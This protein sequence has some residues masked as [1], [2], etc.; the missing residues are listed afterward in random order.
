[1]FTQITH[2][3]T[4]TP[5]ANGNVVCVPNPVPDG[6]STV[7]TATPSSG[8]AIGAWGDACAATPA[9]S[10]SCTLSNVQAPQT[11]SASFTQITH[12]ITV[13]PSANG[14]VVCVPNPVPD[15]GSA[16]C[17]ATPD[18]GFTL[19]AWQGDCAGTPAT[20][21]SC[22]LANVR[23]AGGISA[24][25]TARGPAPQIQTIPAIDRAMQAL[26][27]LLALSFGVIAMGVRRR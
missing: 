5:S 3:I 6:G 21:L 2:A 27:A 1:S 11:V 17:T 15:G 23:A 19:T 20:S 9:G 18:A 7:C 14:N 4:V 16:V 13:T 26:L 12:A 24:Q 10:A 22:T 8:Y 25:F